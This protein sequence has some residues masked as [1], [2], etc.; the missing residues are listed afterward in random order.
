MER[1]ATDERFVAERSLDERRSGAERL[2]GVVG[3]LK[4]VLGSG[5]VHSPAV[6]LF[7]PA[8]N[9]VVTVFVLHRF[10]VSRIGTSESHL[11][12]ALA[13]LRRNDY[14]LLSVEEVVRCFSGDGP[15]LRKAVAFTVDDG[16]LDQATIGAPIFLEFGCPVTIFLTTGFLDGTVVPWWD[17]VNHVFANTTRSHFRSPLGGNDVSYACS[18]DEDRFQSEMAFLTMAKNVTDPERR[19]GIEEL[20]SAAEVA[21]P[22]HPVSPNLP[23]SWDQ[24]RHLERSGVTFGPHT[25]THPILS[26]VG[27]DA[28]EHEITESWRR[29]RQELD[30]PVPVFCY[31]NGRLVDFG[32]RE[33]EITKGLGMSG[34]VTVDEAVADFRSPRTDPD[35]AFRASRVAFPHEFLDTLFCVSGL[36]RVQ[37]G[38]AKRP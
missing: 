32:D 31:P 28:A 34:A 37:R 14:Q 26:H 38:L 27:A 21:L 19:A 2:A 12:K 8:T 35:D 23:M 10:E 3:R 33:I 36:D 1:S 17:S 16:Y 30:R 5:L 7:H 9:G 18:T 25:V 20:A 24:A 29:L 11:R 15:P 22:D 4:R 6:R 13:Y